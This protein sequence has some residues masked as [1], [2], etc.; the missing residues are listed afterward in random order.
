M[1]QPA[2]IFRG[3]AVWIFLEQSMPSIVNPRALSTRTMF[4]NT[5]PRPPWAGL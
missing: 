4:Q 3:D 5:L 1:A 2:A